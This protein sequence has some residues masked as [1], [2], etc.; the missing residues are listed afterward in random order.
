MAIPRRSVRVFLFALAVI[1]AGCGP[2]DVT[3]SSALSRQCDGYITRNEAIRI[4]EN[5]AMQAGRTWMQDYTDAKWIGPAWSLRFNAPSGH[6]PDNDV[7]VDISEDGIITFCMQ[8]D[9]HCAPPF[10]R[11]V[12]RCPI[13][14]EQRISEDRAIELADAHLKESGIA[15]GDLQAT[16]FYHEDPVWFVGF[17]GSLA[18]G[19]HFSV[20]VSPRGGVLRL[21]GGL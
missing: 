1:V 17:L 7:W 8:G 12:A 2:G 5:Y 20:L 15:A 10:D 16:G 3:H 6:P 18:I 14:A 13:P 21:V 9:S 11:S 19:D 4:A